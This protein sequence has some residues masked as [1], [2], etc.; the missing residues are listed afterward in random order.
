MEFLKSLQ[1]EPEQVLNTELSEQGEDEEENRMRDFEEIKN[2]K[3]KRVSQG[4]KRWSKLSNIVRSVSL[5]RT[6]EVKSLPDTVGFIL[7]PSR[8]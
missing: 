7:F 8:N 5:M 2:F 3:P 4:L 1:Q 6:E